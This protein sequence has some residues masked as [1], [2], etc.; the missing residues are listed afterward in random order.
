LLHRL[1]VSGRWF[2]VA[3]RTFPAGNSTEVY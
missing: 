3:S 1:Q 2:V